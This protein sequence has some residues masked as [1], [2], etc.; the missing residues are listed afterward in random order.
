MT[1]WFAIISESNIKKLSL[2]LNVMLIIAII[3]WNDTDKPSENNMVHYNH[4]R[5]IVYFSFRLLFYTIH[6]KRSRHRTIMKCG[7]CPPLK[8][9]PFLVLMINTL[10]S[11]T[12]SCFS[13]G[14][15]WW[16]IDFLDSTGQE[17]VNLIV[18]FG[19]LSQNIFKIK[20]NTS[21][22]NHHFYSMWFWLPYWWT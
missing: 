2:L 13:I 14:E 8:T 4:V 11:M 1:S 7:D 5:T 22:R 6:W 3:A 17:K 19:K 9:T 20:P 15:K 12:K 18:L 16:Q 21:F 10:K